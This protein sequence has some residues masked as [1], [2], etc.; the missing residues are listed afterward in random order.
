MFDE[1]NKHVIPIMHISCLASF[2]F[3][4]EKSKKWKERIEEIENDKGA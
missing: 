3:D 2:V 4:E 1:E